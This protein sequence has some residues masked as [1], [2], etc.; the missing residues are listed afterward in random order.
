MKLDRKQCTAVLCDACL[1][2]WGSVTN[3]DVIV[4]SEIPA[5]VT[6]PVWATFLIWNSLSQ[7]SF[8]THSP[9]PWGVG[10]GSWVTS[11][12][13]NL[14]LNFPFCKSLELGGEGVMGST[15]RERGQQGEE[16]RTPSLCWRVN[17]QAL[18]TS[19]FL[20]DNYGWHNDDLSCALFKTW[21]NSRI[22]IPLSIFPVLI[23]N[24][25]G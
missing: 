8:T 18:P 4:I 15:G 25:K 12:P 9:H 7:S 3:A 24:L 19:D 20:G 6:L 1:G 23:C 10:G 16:A 13:L 17:G 21:F 5:L 22:L 14:W 11:C 2:K